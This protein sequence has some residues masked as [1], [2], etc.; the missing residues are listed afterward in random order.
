MHASVTYDTVMTNLLK[1]TNHQV[2]PALRN[3]LVVGAPLMILVG[4]AIGALA[5]AALSANPILQ[6][7]SVLVTSPMD[8]RDLVVTDHLSIYTGGLD[9][10]RR[11]GATV[12]GD[13]GALGRGKE[14]PYW[15]CLSQSG[16][17]V[18]TYVHPNASP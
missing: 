13:R 15:A 4:G 10:L 1:Y 3:L 14:G 8:A 7:S 12:P 18:L 6:V 17:R 2:R 11:G 16:T 9:R 5:A